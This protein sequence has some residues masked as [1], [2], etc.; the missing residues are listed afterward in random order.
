MTMASIR[1]LFSAHCDPPGTAPIGRATEH[2]SDPSDLWRSGLR[3][4]RRKLLGRE[5]RLKLLREGHNGEVHILIAIGEESKWC[6]G[7]RVCIYDIVIV[8]RDAVRRPYSA[9]DEMA[10]IG[11]PFRPR[12]RVSVVD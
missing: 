2:R 1:R 7:P 11:I 6:C 5:V 9:N 10:A 8:V 4:L 3:Q 12:Q